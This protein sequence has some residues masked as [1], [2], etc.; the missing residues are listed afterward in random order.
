MSRDVAVVFEAISISIRKV[1]VVGVAKDVV[2]WASAT[3]GAVSV[4]RTL[5]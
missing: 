4:A 2:R 1:G 5:G 3:V